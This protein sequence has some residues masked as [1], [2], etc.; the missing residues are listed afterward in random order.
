M[1]NTKTYNVKIIDQYQSGWWKNTVEANLD[2]FPWAA[3]S[4]DDYRPV[5]TARV[6]TD[7]SALYVYM[8]TDETNLRME[9]KGFGHV[10]TDSC[11]EFFISP[12]PSSPKYLNYEFNPAGAMYLS[13][14]TN[15]YDREILNIPEY[16]EVFRVKTEIFDK[17]WNIEYCIP[18]SFLCCFFPSLLLESGHK[19]RG[20]FYKCGENTA[21]PHY[22]CWSPIDLPKPDFHCSEFFGNLVIS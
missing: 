4:T 19:M 12:D 11:M 6:V 8:Q 14:G 3:Q 15:R 16:R 17:G 2:C 18:L 5:T 9:T 13:L 7:D 10:H 22:G 20:N 1:K 21:R